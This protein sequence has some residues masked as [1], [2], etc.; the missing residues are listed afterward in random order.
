[1][2][3]TKICAPQDFF[4]DKIDLKLKQVDFFDNF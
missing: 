3:E 4:S 1:M 2:G